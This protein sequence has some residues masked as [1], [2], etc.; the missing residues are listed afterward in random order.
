MASLSWRFHLCLSPGRPLELCHPLK[1]P[2]APSP[3]VK[4]IIYTRIEPQ[5][6]SPLLLGLISCYYWVISAVTFGLS[7]YLPWCVLSIYIS[8]RHTTEQPLNG[9]QYWTCRISV[10]MESC[11]QGENYTFSNV[12][13]D[14]YTCPILGPLIPLF[15]ISSNVFPWFQSQSGLSHWQCRGK[16]VCREGQLDYR[17][18]GNILKQTQRQ[19]CW[20]RWLSRMSICII[21]VS[22]SFILSLSLSYGNK[23]ILAKSI[24]KAR[25]MSDHISAEGLEINFLLRSSGCRF[26]VLSLFSY[27]DKTKAFLWELL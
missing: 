24:I 21:S 8:Q 20:I 23:Y 14:T 16:S 22:L 18:L 9:S 25:S 2:P 17:L 11:W 4:S 27:N 5:M 6:T 15:W 19:L 12:S 26:I 13:N 3:A 7:I 1:H 10:C